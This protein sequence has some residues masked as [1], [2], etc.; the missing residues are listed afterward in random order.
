[1]KNLKKLSREKQKQ[2]NGGIIKQCISHD[3]CFIGWCCNYM[4]VDYMCPEV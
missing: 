4:C 1:M 3:Q 2:V